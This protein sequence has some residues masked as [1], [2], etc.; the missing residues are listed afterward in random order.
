MKSSL[1]IVAVASA[2]AVAGLLT[3]C[4]S[5]SSKVTLSFVEYYASP[6][7]T[8]VLKQL[9]NDYVKA[10]PN[11]SINLVSPPTDQAE[12]KYQQLFQ[13]GKGIDVM[14]VP[15]GNSGPW[16]KNGWLDDLSKDVSSWPGWSEETDAA[17]E[18][19]Q[20]VGDGKTYMI[21]YGFI[22]VILFYRKDLIQAAGFSGPPKTW[23]DL[24]EQ[25]V[26]IQNPTANQYGFS[27]RGASTAI[28]QLTAVVEA[29]N[30]DQVDPTSGGLK[31][32]NGKSIFSTPEALVAMNDYYTLFKKGS[33]PSSIA[34]GY[35]E[36][37][38]GFTSGQTAFL[39]QTTEVIDIVQ[40]AT[41][42]K[43]DSWATAPIPVGP[44]GIGWRGLGSI[45]WGIAKSTQHRAEAVAF[46]EYLGSGQPAL[47]WAKTMASIPPLKSAENDPFFSQPA[48]KPYLTMNSDIN[49]YRLLSN[50]PAVT[51]N[52][53]WAK[54]SDADIQN[55]LTGKVSSADTLKKWD[56]YLVTHFSQ[57]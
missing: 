56:E 3:S 1:R 20:T 5:G 19:A 38:Q 12:S 13:S 36:N 10:H 25:A 41:T 17:K 33:P 35:P 34:W 40:K 14:E 46:A 27:F 22:S 21:P 45:G 50:S 26:A 39:F 8:P 53:E 11:I 54:L 18:A 43:Q 28:G 55:W 31:L 44:G 15:G 16:V 37:V 4:S 9:I 6:T 7:R 23:G 29:Y 42:L 57:S 48:W 24:V 32:K 49:T 2:V 47:T 52:A 51:W 30:G